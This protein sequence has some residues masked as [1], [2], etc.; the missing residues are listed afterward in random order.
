MSVP[1]ADFSVSEQ[2]AKAIN[3]VKLLATDALKDRTLDEETEAI[4]LTEGTVGKLS[5]GNAK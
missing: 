1:N 2:T 3:T 4:L 5:G